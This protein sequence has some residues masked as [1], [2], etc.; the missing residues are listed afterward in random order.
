MELEKMDAS[1]QMH[2]REDS[3]KSHWSATVLT[4]MSRSDKYEIHVHL[5]HR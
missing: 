4:I 5:T 2:P 3:G 1:V